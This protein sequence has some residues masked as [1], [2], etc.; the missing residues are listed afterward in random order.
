MMHTMPI[1]ARSMAM[2]E[3]ASKA[4]ETRSFL[5]EPV[6]KEEKIPSEP[7]AIGGEKSTYFELVYVSNYN[8]VCHQANSVGYPVS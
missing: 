4:S 6:A 7:Y 3:G 5:L 8:P 2:Y 1:Q